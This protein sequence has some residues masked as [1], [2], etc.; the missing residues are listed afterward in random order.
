MFSIRK[1]ARD[2][3]FEST[4]T[5]F[6]AMIQEAKIS[7]EVTEILVLKFVRGL[8]NVQIADKQHCSLEKVNRSIKTAYDKI[9]KL[10]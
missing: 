1:K 9:F 10:L 4:L 6:N 8:S 5:D 3:L 7:D 2:A